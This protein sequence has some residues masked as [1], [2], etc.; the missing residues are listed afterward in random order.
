MDTPVCVKCRLTTH[1]IKHDSGMT[2]QSW[3]CTKCNVSRSK[4]N[5]FGHALPFVSLGLL[6]FGLPGGETPP[7]AS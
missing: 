3:I 6:V 5:W 4:K 1:M 7:D 2:Y